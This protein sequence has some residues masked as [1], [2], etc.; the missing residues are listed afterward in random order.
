MNHK[1]VAAFF[2]AVPLLVGALGQATELQQLDPLAD[3][4]AASA[5]CR[6]A[7][8][9]TSVYD[10]DRDGYL[11]QSDFRAKCEQSCT[12]GMDSCKGQDSKLS[13]KTGYFHCT[14][15]CPW[16]VTDTYARMR[17]SHTNSFQQCSNACLSGY[18]DCQTVQVKLPPRR[19]S[20]SFSSCG[21]AQG[22]CYAACMGA[23]AVNT[24]HGTATEDSNFPDLCAAACA[25]GVPS[26]RASSGT[27]QCD[28]FS[29]S[30][31]ASCPPTVSDSDGNV[32]PAANSLK[33]CT[34]ACQL[35]ASFCKA[36]LQ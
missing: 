30:C 23:A 34:Y 16:S 7:C 15:S 36:L 13:C 6:K 31:A 5:G 18:N 33:R 29:Q 9:A 8:A 35:G 24:E 12:A 21:E 20:A 27:L 19:R 14:G 17:V 10:P 32:L 28:S 3:C 22:T 26:C 11:K 25:K 2:L 1:S 4:E